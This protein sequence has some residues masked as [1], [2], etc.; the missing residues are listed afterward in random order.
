MDGI[1]W[2]IFLVWVVVTVVVIFAIG[3]VALFS[4]IPFLSDWLKSVRLYDIM[5]TLGYG[6]AVLMSLTAIAVGL[7]REHGEF[8][9]P[10]PRKPRNLILAGLGGIILIGLLVGQ[11]IRIVS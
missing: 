9:K 6:Y 5:T 7:Y 2:R 11:L 4:P 1:Y 10:L 3:G 8:G